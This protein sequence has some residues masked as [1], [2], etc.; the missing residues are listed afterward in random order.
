[1]NAAEARDRFS[2]AYE[3]EL[4]PAERAELD[5]AFAA[6][7]ALLSEYETFRATMEAMGALAREGD[8]VPPPHV[9]G[10]VQ[11]ALRQRSKGRFYRDRFAAL[12]GAQHA[13]W[14]WIGAVVLVSLC[15]IWAAFQFVQFE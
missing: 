6:D 3:G 10:N 9:L 14:L 1:M 2:A 13:L 12:R 8:A 15:V 7:P 4:S 5:A 11:R